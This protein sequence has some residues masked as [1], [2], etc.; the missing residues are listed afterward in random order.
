MARANLKHANYEFLLTLGMLTF[1]SLLY[2]NICYISCIADS[3]CT[4]WTTDACCI[5]SCTEEY[6]KYTGYQFWLLRFLWLFRPA[7]STMVL[8]P[9]RVNENYF[10]EN[11]EPSH[12]CFLSCY[13]Q[14]YFLLEILCSRDGVCNLANRDWR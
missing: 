12:V 9:D 11:F 4:S 13:I 8:F 3:Y 10:N 7:Y 14:L 5:F 6:R 2:R 1:G